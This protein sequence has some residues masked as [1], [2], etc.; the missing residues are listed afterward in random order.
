MNFSPDLLPSAL[1]MS[2]ALFI[3]LGVLL[4]VYCFTRR[5][6]NKNVG[7]SQE[8][9]IRILANAYV[10]V[11]KSISIVEIPGAIL[12]IGVAGDNICLLTKI[13]D[14]NTLNKYKKVED[15]KT[16]SSFYDQIKKVSLKF[17]KKHGGRE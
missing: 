5:L 10:G 15:G 13:E 16:S 12:V 8:K 1:K 17:N 9:L 6:L 7:G 2:I 4:T 3:V 11:K 14:E